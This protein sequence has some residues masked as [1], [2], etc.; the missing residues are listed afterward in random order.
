MITL[1]TYVDKSLVGYFAIGPFDPSII[2]NKRL[3]KYSSHGSEM[4]EN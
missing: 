3:T 2:S 4:L 1:H